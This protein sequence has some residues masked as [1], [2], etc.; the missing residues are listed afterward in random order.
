MKL[1]VDESLE[2]D[3]DLDRNAFLLNEEQWEAFLALLDRPLQDK[4]RLRRLATEELVATR[5]S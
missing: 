2:E 1:R 4:P 3:Q 5:R